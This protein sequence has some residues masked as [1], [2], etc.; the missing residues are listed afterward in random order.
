MKRGKTLCITEVATINSLR[1]IQVV[2]LIKLKKASQIN[3]VIY[4]NSNL[5][6]SCKMRNKAPT[7][8]GPLLT[9]INAFYPTKRPARLLWPRAGVDMCGGECT[10]EEKHAKEERKR[11]R[12]VEKL[13]LKDSVMLQHK[14]PDPRLKAR[15]EHLLE[16][17]RQSTSKFELKEMKEIED[18][19][20]LVPVQWLQTQQSSACVQRFVNKCKFEQKVGRE[21]MKRP[22]AAADEG[23]VRDINSLYAVVSYCWSEYDVR[24]L[25]TDI[26]EAIKLHNLDT[27]VKYVWVDIFCVPQY[28]QALLIRHISA[29]PTIYA[30]ARYHLIVGNYPHTRVWCVM[31]IAISNARKY[32]CDCEYIGAAILSKY[33][34]IDSFLVSVYHILKNGVLEAKM[35]KAGLK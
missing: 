25:C 13:L 35:I 26:W 16:K 11:S 5:L 20:L 2:Q 28:D 21:L 4:Y 6:D 8:V 14:D 18:V 9:V 10:A 3:T 23:K 22:T 34:T 29:L 17:L 30:N 19:F 12:D 27:V 7:R 32:F 15:S 31:E 1:A 24:S 33:E